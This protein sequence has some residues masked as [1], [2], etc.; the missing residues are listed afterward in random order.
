MQCHI[1]YIN[2]QS[3]KEVLRLLAKHLA[4][5]LADWVDE[6][7]GANDSRSGAWQALHDTIRFQLM[8]KPA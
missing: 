3:V 2:D 8:S 1:L 4:I 5:H 7:I 6:L